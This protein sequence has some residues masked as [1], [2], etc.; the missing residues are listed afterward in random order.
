M[1]INNTKIIF[2]KIKIVRE[3]I[4][5]LENYYQKIKKRHDEIL[6]K[7]Y[8]MLKH[9]IKMINIIIKFKTLEM[10]LNKNFICTILFLTLSI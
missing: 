1:V 4:R 3:F 2:I 9:V 10:I 7:L 6:T 8:S 5:S